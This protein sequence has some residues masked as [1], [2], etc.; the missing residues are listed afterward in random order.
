MKNAL[1]ILGI[2]F[3][4]SGLSYLTGNS[5]EQDISTG[6][7]GLLFGGGMIYISTRMKKKIKGANQQE[8]KD[9]Y[10]M[11]VA[12]GIRNATPY[13]KL[14]ELDLLLWSNKTGE[15]LK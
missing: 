5:V 3:I 14:D 15:I 7:F 12:F 9:Y 13:I 1:L 10:R 11:A 4:L 6:I 2:L 8:E